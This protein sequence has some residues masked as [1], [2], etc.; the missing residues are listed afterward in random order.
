[1]QGFERLRAW[2]EWRR[3]W[4]LSFAVELMRWLQSLH[5]K[6]LGSSLNKT[7]QFHVTWLSGPATRIIAGWYSQWS[8]KIPCY[9][10]IYSLSKWDILKY[11]QIYTID[12]STYKFKQQLHDSAA[13]WSRATVQ[14]IIWYHLLS[15]WWNSAV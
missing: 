14:G 8:S 10:H 11:I 12:Y 9:M 1:M 3:K 2:F 6:I 13:K 5:I 4:E 15:L 7:V